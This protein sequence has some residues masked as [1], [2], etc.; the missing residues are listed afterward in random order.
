MNV[1]SQGMLPVALIAA[2]VPSPALPHRPGDPLSFFE[3]STESVSTLNVLMRKP[4]RVRSVGRGVIAPD[5]S[6]VLVQRV[7]EEGQPPRDRRWQ[8]RQVAPDQF[9]GTMSEAKGPVTIE[10]VGGGYRFR[11]KMKGNLSVEQWL[12]PLPG[13]KSAYSK[14]L[15]RK[16]GFAVA[17]SEGIIH[18]INR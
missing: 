5:G 15:V 3:G 10:R 11:Y 1:L 6:L 13:G 14:L 12:T 17:R 4:V 16:L 9:S 2:L 18:K 7:E 8:I